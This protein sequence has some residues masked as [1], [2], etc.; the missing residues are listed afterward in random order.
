VIILTAQND[1]I[2]TPLRLGSIRV[3]DVDPAA[4]VA[5]DAVVLTESSA[6][7]T[8]A[9]VWRTVAAGEHYIEESSNGGKGYTFARG[10]RC[11]AAEN[12]LIYLYEI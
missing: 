6:G 3:V 9:V 7:D 11:E 12:M 5:G 1:E 10:V 4:V 2:T 8:E